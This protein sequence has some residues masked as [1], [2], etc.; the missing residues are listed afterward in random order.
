MPIIKTPD[1]I[2]D[3]RLQN[4]HLDKKLISPKDIQKFNKELPDV[5]ENYDLIT[6]EMIFEELRP[7]EPEEIEE[8]AIEEEEEIEVEEPETDQ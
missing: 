2:F 6:K 5:S 8:D 3:V 7:D 1:Q 4:H